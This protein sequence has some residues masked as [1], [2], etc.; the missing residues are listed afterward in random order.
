MGFFTK[1]NSTFPWN[2]LISN[3]DFLTLWNSNEPF[4]IFKHST[5]CSISSMAL[6]HFES[7]FHTDTNC[8]L[9]LLDLLIHRD[10]SNQIAELTGVQHQSP[11]IILIK[12]KQILLNA[13]HEN[14]SANEIEQKCH[15]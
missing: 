5:R 8:Q 4:L 6:R 15:E 2:H 7:E 1:Q 12:N 13:S 10:I 11:Q 9:F 3:D 14:I